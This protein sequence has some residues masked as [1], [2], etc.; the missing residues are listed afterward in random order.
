MGNL[1]FSENV[2]KVPKITLFS[3][4]SGFLFEYKFFPTNALLIPHLGQHCIDQHGALAM[5]SFKKR[6]HPRRRKI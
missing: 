2:V 1:S 3:I 5:P 4:S 6:S